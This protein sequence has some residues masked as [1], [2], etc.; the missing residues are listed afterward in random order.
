LD[1]TSPVVIGRDNGG[2]EI[3]MKVSHNHDLAQGCPEKVDFVKDDVVFLI[4]E[5]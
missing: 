1:K 4:G 2:T 5:R 3:V